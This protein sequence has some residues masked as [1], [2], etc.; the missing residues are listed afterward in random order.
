MVLKRFC[1]FDIDK[2]CENIC[3]EEFRRYLSITWSDY[4][5]EWK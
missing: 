4:N 2:Y 3:N 5:A 1:S